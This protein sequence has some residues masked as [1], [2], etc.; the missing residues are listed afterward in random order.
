MQ[1]RTKLPTYAMVR[2]ESESLGA[3][4]PERANCV[5]TFA[6]LAHIL[7]TFINVW[8][9]GNCARGKGE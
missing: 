4:A 1:Q 2:L 8:K 7:G 9:M 3:V 6:K 5:D